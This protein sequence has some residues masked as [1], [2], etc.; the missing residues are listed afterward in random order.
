MTLHT[1]SGD[2]I[3]SVPIPVNEP[4]KGYGPGSSEKKS[5]KA[6]VDAMAKECIDIPL[7]V[8]GKEIFTGKTQDVVMPH[9]HRHVLADYHKAGEK[10]IQ[11]AIADASL[12]TRIRFQPL[13]FSRHVADEYAVMDNC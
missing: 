6:K 13:G 12:S 5:I 2:A 11:M 8:G 10:E 1:H 7:I 9:D 3:F 4:I